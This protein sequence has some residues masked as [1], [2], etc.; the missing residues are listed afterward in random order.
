MEGGAYK[1]I[2]EIV[3]QQNR[4]FT[5]LHQINAFIVKTINRIHVFSK[6]HLHK[7]LEAERGSKNKEFLRNLPG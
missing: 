6:E 7:E 1:R 2:V 5:T 4:I 3:I